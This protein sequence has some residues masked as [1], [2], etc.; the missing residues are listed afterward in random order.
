[1]ATSGVHSIMMVK[2]AQPGEEGGA[3]APS[4]TLLYLPSRA[5]VVVYAL[6][7][8]ADTLL[9]FLLNLSLLC[10][11]NWC[12]GGGIEP[13]SIRWYLPL[14]SVDSVERPDTKDISTLVSAVS[15]QAS[16]HSFLQYRACTALGCR[17][18]ASGKWVC[19]ASEFASDM[20]SGK[21][22]TARQTVCYMSGVTWSQRGHHC[23]KTWPQEPFHWLACQML[24]WVSR[25]VSLQFFL[26]IY[27][28]K[29]IL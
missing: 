8:R 24:V 28:N 23:R 15:Q 21:N 4:F 22:H 14:S 11:W 18:V 3:R 2:F 13:I 6:A 9:L 16:L 17:E 5:K 1:M 27:P 12:R 19:R 25:Q 10:G 26:F 7:E 20:P 29:I